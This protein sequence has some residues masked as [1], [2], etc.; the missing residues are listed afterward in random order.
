MTAPY[1]FLV[2][3]IGFH[4]ILRRK[5]E[6]NLKTLKPWVGKNGCIQTTGVS[7]DFENCVQLL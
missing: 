7:R 1:V 6:G 2:Y 5:A 4:G 3:K